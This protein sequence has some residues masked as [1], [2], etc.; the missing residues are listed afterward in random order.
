MKRASL[1]IFLSAAIPVCAQ[2][3]NAARKPCA[4]VYTVIQRDTLG[5]VTKGISNPKNLKW[6]D[7]DLQKKYPDVCYAMPD[8]SVT[9]VF[10]IT[11]TPATYHGT[12]VET[13]RETTPTS[14]TITDTSTGDTA[15]YQ[16][17][18]TTTSS[19]AVPYSFDYGVFT[20]TV[21]TFGSD[22]KPVP[23]HRFQQKGIYHTY[24]GI[25]LGGRGHHP[26]KALIEDAAK[27]IHEGGLEDSFQSSQEVATA[28]LN[29]SASAPSTQQ[30]APVATNQ[31]A[32][33]STHSTIGAFAEGNPDVRHDGVT[34]TAM[35]P[36]G[37]ANKAGM[38]AGDVILAINDHYLFTIRELQE[39][40]SHYQP[41]TRINVRYRR[42]SSIYETQIIVGQSQ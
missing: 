14:G 36:S 42:Y 33:V 15:T 37:P 8:K 5:N 9:T 27:W 23:R 21:E 18:Q 30:P 3:H 4:I 24:A 40:I 16:G 17:T 28:V 41:G 6:A 10:V 35:P 34:V 22:G 2:N 39:E 26:A 13:D 25:P 7:K 19:T 20:L 29:V 12:R 11:V 31:T 32:N 38:N 1:L